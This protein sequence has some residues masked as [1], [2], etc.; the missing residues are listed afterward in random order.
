MRTIPKVD[1]HDPFFQPIIS[2]VF[3]SI[4]QIFKALYL[5]LQN[6]S[7]NIGVNTLKPEF[8]LRA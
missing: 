1:R 8:N 4:Q 6:I 3:Q 2:E 5:M 7:Q